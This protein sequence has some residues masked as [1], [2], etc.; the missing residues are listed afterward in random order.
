MDNSTLHDAKQQQQQQHA[1]VAADSAYDVFKSSPSSSSLQQ[2]LNLGPVV[3]ALMQS[4]RERVNVASIR[5]L[6]AC[7]GVG[8][9]EP[10]NLPPQIQIV[11]R[12]KTNANFFLTNYLLATAVVFFFLLLFFHRIQLLVCIIVACGW[13]LVLTKK[14]SELDHVVA[15]GKRIGEQEVLLFTTAFT[16]LFLIFFI[17][18]TIIF[19]LSTTFVGSALHALLRN[20]RLKDDSFSHKVTTTAGDASVDMA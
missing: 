14:T 11:A 4:V 17:L 2:Q 19:S 12:L 9:A 15:F 13:Y 7:I 6:F 3:N 10:F 18:P 20:N 1:P 5:T 8:E 16:I